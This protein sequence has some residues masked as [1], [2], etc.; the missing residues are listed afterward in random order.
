MSLSAMSWLTRSLASAETPA[1]CGVSS[2]LGQPWKCGDSGSGSVPKTSMAAPPSCPLFSAAASAAS[3]TMPPRAV[4]MSTA[5]GFIAA[6]RLAL[7]RPRVE[8]TKGTCRLT[9]SDMLMTS[10]SPAQRTPC[11]SKAGWSSSI[12]ASKAVS[13]MPTPRARVAVSWPMEPK[14]MRPRVLPPISR[15]FDKAL[16]GHCPAATAAVDA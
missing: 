13:C 16:R 7:K 9:T 3:S 4:L 11:C 5:P 6:M 10:S 14:P 1:M 12:M 2:R 15:P 8:S